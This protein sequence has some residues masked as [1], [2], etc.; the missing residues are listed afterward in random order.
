MKPSD[1]DVK[2]NHS[3]YLNCSTDLG[4]TAI[5][6]YHGNK[7]VYNGNAILEPYH[8]RFEIDMNAWNGTYRYNLVI[9]SVQPGDAG[10]YICAEDEGVGDE[11]SVQLIVLGK[12]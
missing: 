5:V 4:P 3:A 12:H 10:E 2:L 8:K 1:T 9:H 6:W 7:S 11:Y